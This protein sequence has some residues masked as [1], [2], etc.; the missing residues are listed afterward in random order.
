ML[1]SNTDIHN[2]I[3]QKALQKAGAGTLKF[4]LNNYTHQ[5][6]YEEGSF[7]PW[8]KRKDL[9]NEKPILYK[10]GDMKKSFHVEYGKGNFTVSNTKSYS[11]YHNEGTEHLPKRPILYDDVKIQKI[12]EDAVFF[13]LDKLFGTKK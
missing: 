12:I 9:K 2:A 5:G 8:K 4:F 11:K 1:P 3:E 6:Y 10:S 13:E 7:L